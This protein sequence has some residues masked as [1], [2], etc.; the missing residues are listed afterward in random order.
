MPSPS[1][2][3][4]AKTIEVEHKTFAFCDKRDSKFG[5]VCKRS[6]A[7]VNAIAKARN[8]MVDGLMAKAEREND[9]LAEAGED[10]RR[11]KSTAG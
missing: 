3:W 1:S 4:V 7:M 2:S 8:E 6:F 5:K 11:R 10:A 9:P